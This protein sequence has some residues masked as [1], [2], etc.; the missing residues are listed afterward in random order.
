MLNQAAV[1]PFTF[2]DPHIRAVDIRRDLDAVA[3]LIEECFASTM[4]EDGY[5]YLRQLRKSA[6]DAR[7]L[8]FLTNYIDDLWAPIQGVVWEEQGRIIGNLTLL[9]FQ[10]KRKPIYLI[11]NVAVVEEQRN[12]GIGRL[13][14]QSALGYAENRGASA[15]WLQVRD[16]NPGAIHLY[17]SLGFVEKVRRT[18][19][20]GMPDDVLPQVEDGYTVS[21]CSAAD[22]D[23][24]YRML[25]RI[26]H[27]EVTW[28]LPVNLEKLRPSLLSQFARLI[29][30]ETR[31]DWALRFER[32][33]LG[34]ISWEAAKTWTDNLWVACDAANQDLVLRNLLPQV[35]NSVQSKRPQ[36]INYPAGQAEKTF[37]QAGFHKHVTLLW[38]EVQLKKGEPLSLSV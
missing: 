32:Q 15:A 5:A 36:S 16:D 13:L 22:W 14:T 31:R 23:I 18:A 8:E 38:M 20:H 28:N 30:G 33:F 17:Q 1:S 24:Q 34:A 6:Q 26:Y 21:A 10:K 11:A 35:L 2:A 19:W 12:R 29:G 7:M 37:Q 9:P 4:D 27:P 3:D 25:N